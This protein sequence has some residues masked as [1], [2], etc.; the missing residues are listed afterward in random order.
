MKQLLFLL[1]IF[2]QTISTSTSNIQ[3]RAY[4]G[5]LSDYKL[6]TIKFYGAGD[7]F[8]F[9]TDLQNLILHKT[10]KGGIH[11]TK[12]TIQ[13]QLPLY[14]TTEHNYISDFHVFEPCSLNVGF[15]I[16]K[17]IQYVRLRYRNR[18]N[19]RTSKFHNFVIINDVFK[20]RFIMN[21]DMKFAANIMQASV[22][23]MNDTNLSLNW[24]VFCIHCKSYWNIIQSPL[25]PR[26]FNLYSLR[27]YWFT[28]TVKIATYLT[29]DGST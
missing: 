17:Q 24:A 11:F 10:L 21:A 5:D 20:I 9:Y 14:E 4:N 15:N 29:S 2:L 18:D 16:E 23:A 13:T 26:K 6:C 1:Q 22:I 28:D 27:E 7:N 8:S 3:P 25:N 19:F 12:I